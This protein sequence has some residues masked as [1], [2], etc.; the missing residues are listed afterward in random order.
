[1]YYIIIY[2]C[3]YVCMHS[4]MYVGMYLYNVCIYGWGLL[5]LYFLILILCW[6]W[7]MCWLQR[8]S[9]EEVGHWWHLLMALGR[10][11]GSTLPGLCWERDD[12]W[13]SFRP[14]QRRATGSGN[15][16]DW[17]PEDL[18]AKAGTSSTFSNNDWLKAQK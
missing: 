14:L 17:T 1:M 12:G 15:I 2:E 6:G 16:Q 4:Y 3:M 13:A 8:E 5:L 7:T 10:W 18:P 9:S 11:T